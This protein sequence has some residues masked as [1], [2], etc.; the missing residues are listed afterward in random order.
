MFNGQITYGNM[1]SIVI[2]MGITAIVLLG[3]VLLA[4]AL[5]N[6]RK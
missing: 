6:K 2:V 1:T 5:L 4:T 3:G